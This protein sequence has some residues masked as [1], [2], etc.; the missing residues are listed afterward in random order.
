MAS[1]RHGAAQQPCDAA[2]GVAFLMCQISCCLVHARRGAKD[3]QYASPEWTVAAT[4][5]I[6]NLATSS[7][8]VRHRS[9][10]ACLSLG[11]GGPRERHARVGACGDD[12]NISPLR[13]PFLQLHAQPCGLCLRQR[14]PQTSTARTERTRAR[15]P[16]TPDNESSHNGGRAVAR[17]RSSGGRQS[18]RATVCTTPPRSL[19]QMRGRE[20]TAA[21]SARPQGHAWLDF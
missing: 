19:R 4:A 20:R 21:K 8:R 11:T 9:N 10:S 15:H 5:G 1:D 2:E 7:V 14:A 6:C 16:A 17:Q 12:C 18:Q 13:R 3:W